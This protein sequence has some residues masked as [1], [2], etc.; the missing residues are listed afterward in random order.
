MYMNVDEVESALIALANAHPTICQRITLP[1]TTI[2]GRT[3][4]AV[5]LGSRPA[6]SVDAYYLTGGVHAREW[7]SCEILINLATDLCDAYA[8]GTGVA[9]GGKQFSAPEVRALIEQLNIIV[10]PCVNPDGRHFSQTSA[11]LWRKN[12]NPASSSGDP[13]KIGVDINRN[14][15]FLW[16]FQTAFAAGAQGSYLA[17]ANPQEDTFHG[18][19]PQSEP[20]SKNIK[21]IHDTYTRIRWYVDVHSY[22]E[23]I[24]YVWGDDEMQVTDPSR[25]FTNATYNHARGVLGDDYN[26]YIPDGDLSAVQNLAAAFSRNLF[27]VRGKI[28]AAKPGFSLYAT[29]GTNDDYAYSRHIV[30]PSK[31]KQLA[32]TVEWGTE[33]QP[34]WSEMEDIIRDVS[35]GLFGLGL[36]GLGIDSYIVTDRDTFSNYEVETTSSY[37]DAFYVVID[38]FSPSALGLPTARPSIRFL[39]AVGGAAISSISA[40]LTGASLEDPSAFDTPQR[41]R[42]TFRIQFSDTS[43]FTSETR[44]VLLEA[45]M[46]GIVDVAEV[47]LLRQPNPYML[48]GAVSWLSTDVR[49][50]QLRP[51]QRVNAFSGVTLEDPS[52][53][54]DAP[55]RYIRAFLDE[56]RAS[57]NAPSLPFETI[58]LDEDASR[59]EL[60]RSVGGTRTFNFAVAK[61]RYRASSIDATDVRVFFRTFN[62][63]VSNLTYNMAGGDLQNYRRTSNGQTPLLG[64]NHFF[65]GGGNQIVS[66]PYFAQARIDSASASMTTQSDDYNKRT[67]H[68]AGGTEAVEYFG[69]WL[70]FNQTEPQFPVNVSGDGPFSGRVPIVQLV[71]G[72]HQCLVAEVRYQP[73]A[74]DPIG[75]GK[76][77]ATS[78]RL[79]QRNL[80][81]VESDNP[82]G[83]DS[84]VVVHTLLLKPSKTVAKGLRSDAMASGEGE[85]NS[86]Y[87]ELVFDWRELPVGTKGSLYLPDFSADEVLRLAEELRS[88]P[89]LLHRI[90]QNTVGFEAR[91]VG[92]I[93]VPSHVQA[94]TPA[95]LRLELPLT[96]KA[97]EHFKVD[98]QQHSGLTRHLSVR[99]DSPGE[100]K[101]DVSRRDYVLSKRHV[102]G[103]FRLRVAVSAG[104]PLLDV[105]VRN[106][107]VLK[108]IQQAI[109]TNDSWHAVFTRY[110]AAFEAAVRDLG[111]DP[112]QVPASADDP[113]VPGAAGAPPHARS[114]TGKIREV[115]FDCF[116]ELAGIAL[117]TCGACVHIRCTERRIG[118][119]AWRACSERLVVTVILGPT[120][121]PEIHE[122][123]IR[124]GWPRHLGKC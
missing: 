97:G 119:L 99:E 39:T 37:D 13:A 60:S 90:D 120:D 46:A 1:H 69:C 59:L 6:N 51:N 58:S 86:R 74:T 118:D 33:F 40:V 44:V 34:P 57:G 66:I 83:A 94:A 15:D 78:D 4:H 56:L 88:G 62:T 11:G 73:G 85:V 28:Y 5:L 2:E 24:L 104:Q 49:V 123:I 114:V 96:V 7:G 63:M 61:V 10:F 108:Y 102:L 3:S 98:V 124:P 109:P 52:A 80:S 23:D 101:G 29:S 93:P 92:Y 113:G 91:G 121:P 12:R 106:L 47:Q 87:D 105:K 71:R 64:T 77:P 16:D 43:A 116:G 31:S 84:H 117:E 41:V 81:I 65:S 26:E 76:T 22:S 42:F 35:A 20:E 110:I 50:F 21:Y 100:R 25:S 89:Q 68:H 27:E 79:A 111:V 48:D 67:L 19:A 95:L 82:G 38:G 107:A 53:H 72:I 122:L 17:S 45:T 70:D 55:I 54:S 32:F 14:Q 9:Y 103:A 115:I 30:D 36:R 75:N 8:G 112:T 18:T